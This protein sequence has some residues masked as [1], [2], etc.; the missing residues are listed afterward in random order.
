MGIALVDA[1][2][3]VTRSFNEGDPPMGLVGPEADELALRRAC[4]LYITSKPS[5]HSGYG[6]YLLKETVARNRGTFSLSSGSATI[7]GYLRRKVTVIDARK[8]SAWRG[9]IVN[10]I[11]DLNQDLP[12]L[13][14]YGEMPAPE[15][16]NADDLFID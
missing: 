2:I 7:T 9:T 4:E 1:G 13:D 15:G 12:I 16:Y 14:V 6:L 10:L 3:G 8:H 5:R 11:L